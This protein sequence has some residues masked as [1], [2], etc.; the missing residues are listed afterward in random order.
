MRL[1]GR[2]TTYVLGCANALVVDRG[3]T[4]VDFLWMAPSVTDFGMGMGAAVGGLYI[5][6]ITI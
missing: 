4:V 5:H 1:I 2:V 6:V 3:A